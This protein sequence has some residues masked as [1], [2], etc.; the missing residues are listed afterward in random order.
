MCILDLVVLV[1][2]TQE[3]PTLESQYSELLLN[4]CSDRRQLKEMEQSLLNLLESTSG[5]VHIRTFCMHNSTCVC[6][7]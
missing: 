5:M 7:L 4:I 6:S 3:E 1:L 2:H